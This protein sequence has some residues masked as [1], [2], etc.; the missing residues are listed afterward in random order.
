MCLWCPL[1]LHATRAH[2]KLAN[3]DC[4]TT[5]TISPCVNHVQKRST[6]TVSMKFIGTLWLMGPHSHDLP[7]RK[8]GVSFCESGDGNR[9]PISQ[10]SCVQRRK[11]AIVWR[12]FCLWKFLHTYFAGRQTSNG[13]VGNSCFDEHSCWRGRKMSSAI[14]HTR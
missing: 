8:I 2:L 14:I 4:G 12:H 7:M 11:I 5:H 3:K 6:D 13:C 10:E 9:G 1:N